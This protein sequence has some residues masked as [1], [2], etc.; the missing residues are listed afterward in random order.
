M[1]P[2]VALAGLKG[3]PSHYVVLDPMSGSGM[4]VGT[5]A[6]LGLEAIGYDLDPLACMISRVKR[7]E[8]RGD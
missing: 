2:E 1:A 7:N 6:K 8:G 4:V 3:L 5:A